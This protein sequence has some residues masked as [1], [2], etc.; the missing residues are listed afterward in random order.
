MSQYKLKESEVKKIKE[1]IFINKCKNHNIK[2]LA[3]KYKISTMQIARIT[4][5]DCWK[6][7]LPKLTRNKKVLNGTPISIQKKIINDL[8]KNV[9]LNKQI[10]VKYSVTETVVSRLK[11]K[12]FE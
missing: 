12:N 5:G 6:N 10:A 11:S 3:K 9:L 4:R 1:E 7:V 8:E 2:S